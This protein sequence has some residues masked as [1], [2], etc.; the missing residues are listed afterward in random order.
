MV[1][2]YQ[3][4]DPAIFGFRLQYMHRQARINCG[5]YQYYNLE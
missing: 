3:W 5:N 4:G 1:A 2:E